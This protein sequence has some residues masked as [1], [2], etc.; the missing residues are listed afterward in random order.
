M[1]VYSTT[2]GELARKLSGG[3]GNL[4]AMELELRDNEIL[5]ACTTNGEV[6]RW[7]WR[8]GRLQETLDLKLKKEQEVLSFNLINLYGNS[9]TACA[10]VTTRTANEEQI[11]WCVMDT[12]IAESLN[13]PCKL[14][15]L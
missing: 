9:K 2:T 11:K 12:S 10:F 14:K 3:N 13:V 6:I 15:L 1:R 7:F 4:V 8:S 5:V